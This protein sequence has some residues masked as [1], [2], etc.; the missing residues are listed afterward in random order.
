MKQLQSLPKPI[1]RYAPLVLLILVLML[2]VWQ[3]LTVLHLH[4]RAGEIIDAYRREYFPE[5]Q[6]YLNCQLPL[7]T[8]LPQDSRMDQ[9]IALLDRA[10][11]IRF[12]KAQ[13]QLL[14]GRVYCL[15]GDFSAAINAFK[16]FQEIRAKSPL[17][18]IEAGFAYLNLALMGVEVENHLA[19][20]REQFEALGYGFE[21]FLAEANAAFQKEAF[22]DAY[23]WYRIAVLY[24]PLPEEA[25]AKFELLEEVY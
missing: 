11:G 9:A 1:R 4:A 5:F 22:A 13:T 12:F 6:M 8:S 24:Q 20:A 7:L 17:G 25:A 23:T 21:Y 14:L 2:A 16:A 15:S 19:Q 18:R 3:P 10:V